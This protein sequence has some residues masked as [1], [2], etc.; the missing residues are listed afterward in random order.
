MSA[1][2]ST[3]A[4]RDRH[5]RTLVQWLSNPQLLDNEELSECIEALMA[6]SLDR[7]DSL[8]SEAVLLRA[9]PGVEMDSEQT[10]LSQG[11]Q[12]VGIHLVVR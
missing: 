7:W 4:L 10:P 3:S 12:R 11:V 5:V 9:D 1:T 2:E 8:A 6:E